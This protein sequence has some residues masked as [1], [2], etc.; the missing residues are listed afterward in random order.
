MVQRCVCILLA[1]Y[2]SRHPLLSVD[3]ITRA[4]N[5]TQFLPV[6]KEVVEKTIA[7]MSQRGSY[8]RNLERILGAGSTL[9]LGTEITEIKYVDRDLM[10]LTILTHE[11]GLQH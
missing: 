9:A 2:Q 7:T 10:L 11:V 5:T 1:D 8:Y 3:D 6:E 4:V